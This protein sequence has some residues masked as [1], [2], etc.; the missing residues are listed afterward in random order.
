MHNMM[1]LLAFSEDSGMASDVQNVL[2]DALLLA[3]S[4]HSGMAIDV[5]RILH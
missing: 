4:E 5:Q 1:L 3:F 2:H